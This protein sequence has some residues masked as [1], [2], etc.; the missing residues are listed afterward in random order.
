MLGKL[1]RR[2]ALLWWK[3]R[4]HRGTE[5]YSRTWRV[6]QPKTQSEVTNK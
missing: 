6:Q 3:L 4:F 1:I 5:F 2:L